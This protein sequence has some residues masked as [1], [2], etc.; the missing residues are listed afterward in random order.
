MAR[1]SRV[2]DVIPSSGKLLDTDLDVVPLAGHFFDMVG[3][4]T[5]DSVFFIADSL[6]PENILAKYH[7]FFLLDVGAHLETLGRLREATADYFVPGHGTV[8][9]DITGLIEMNGR[10]IQEILDT[11]LAITERPSTVEDVLSAVCE[12]YRIT[13]DAHQYVLVSSTLKSYLAYLKDASRLTVS[14]QG[15][16]SLW[17][18]IS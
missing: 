17:R 15:G 2:T 12:R 6:F 8:S 14:F 3:I 9:T 10:K 16:R 13:L 4:R 18:K 11:I 1:P 5:P 7:A